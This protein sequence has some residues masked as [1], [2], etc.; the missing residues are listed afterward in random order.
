M[1]KQNVGI[2]GMEGQ[3]IGVN[4]PGGK[5]PLGSVKHGTNL[6][7]DTNLSPPTQW[8]E[9][10]DRD[11][12]SGKYDYE[13]LKDA[14]K[15]CKGVCAAPLAV[16]C[17]VVKSHLPFEQAGENLQAAC[18]TQK[19][20]ICKNEDQDDK[21]CEDYEIR[22]QC[23]PDIDECLE[24]TYKCHPKAKCENTHGGYNCICEEGY[25]GDGQ[26]CFEGA[27]CSAWGDPHYTTFDGEKYDFQGLCK[28]RMV[29]PCKD[30][31]SMP[32]FKVVSKNRS[33][34][35]PRV[36]VSKY[37]DIKVYGFDIQLEHKRAYVDGNQITPPRTYKPAHANWPDSS[38]TIKANLLGLEFS[39]DFGLIV[40]FTAGSRYELYVPKYLRNNTCG[41]CGDYDGSENGFI[42]PNGTRIDDPLLAADAWRSDDSDPRCANVTAPPLECD[43]DSIAS[44]TQACNAMKDTSK[45][46]DCLNV[47]GDDISMYYD[48]CVYD[49]CLF[50]ETLCDSLAALADVCEEKGAPVVWRSSSLCPL[51]CP[52]NM[53]YEEAG[54][55]CPET[56]S[57]PRGSCSEPSSTA[58]GC[59]CNS[60]YVLS[61]LECVL[62]EN[63]GC[64]RGNKYYAPGEKFFEKDCEALCMC[65]S[66]RVECDNRVQCHVHGECHTTADG[67]SDCRCKNGY[68]G[69][70]TDCSDEDECSQNNHQCSPNARCI[71]QH[72]GYACTC[73]AGYTGD[74]FT[75]KDADE[76][77]DE[78]DACSPNAECRNEV[79]T[80]ACVCKDG[81]ISFANGRVCIER[82]PQEPAIPKDCGPFQKEECMECA[83]CKPLP[84]GHFTC[85]CPPGTVGDGRKGEEHTG[86]SMPQCSEGYIKHEDGCYKVFDKPEPFDEADRRCQAEGGHL[87]SVLDQKTVDFLKSQMELLGHD[88]KY[89][90][91]YSDRNMEGIYV[92]LD[93][94]FSEYSNWAAGE[95]TADDRLAKDCVAVG[96][97]TEFKFVT[98]KCNI[99]Q[100]FVCRKPLSLKN[101]PKGWHQFDGSCYMSSGEKTPFAEAYLQCAARGGD[102]AA[103]TSSMEEAVL[104]EIVIPVRNG[105]DLWIGA[106]QKDDGFDWVDGISSFDS[107]SAWAQGEPAN[108]QGIRCLMADGLMKWKSVDCDL[109]LGFICEKSFRNPYVCPPGT[110]KVRSVC[111]TVRTDPSDFGSNCGDRGVMI[112]PSSAL[113]QTWIRSYLESQSELSDPWICTCFMLV[114][115]H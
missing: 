70:G 44:A 15:D 31:G 33:I 53:H 104:K 5:S 6:D 54:P 41:L 51:E 91:G 94:S 99:E 107:F 76:C 82:V 67:T 26:H 58:S 86:C 50:P 24:N 8:S 37:L 42:L 28:Y 40:K 29:E 49:T 114:F 77:E 10:C 81:Y 35:K 20:L 52:E 113:E 16:E 3:E 57:D 59:Q 89:W 4:A 18:T 88:G 85:V 75:C 43:G 79:G 87:A 19:G 78:T 112:R 34:R 2:S 110:L 64:V 84:G 46:G 97:A 14:I 45:F 92:W 48:A 74:G 23:P 80:Y 96:K 100:G 55:M 63:C 36:S 101:C 103:V 73:I 61:G 71:N 12:P 115:E 111:L 7:I 68:T 39:T 25:V 13:S 95:P 105:S 22:F 47:I 93:N 83:E 60:G 38:I 9:W 32:D 69:S 109:S 1:S 56:C 17:R 27:K 21:K 106:F 90:I 30:F 72:G 98:Q 62:R 108:V 102:L 66:G 11:N 65:T